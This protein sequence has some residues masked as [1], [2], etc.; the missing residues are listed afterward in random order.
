MITLLLLLFMLL[1]SLVI[2]FLTLVKYVYDESIEVTAIIIW[3]TSFF[4]DQTLK[5]I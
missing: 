4:L 3:L 2:T 1:K 5:K